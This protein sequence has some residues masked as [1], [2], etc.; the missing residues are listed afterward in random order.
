MQTLILSFQDFAKRAA[1]R[2]KAKSNLLKTL[3]KNTRGRGHS[4]N[5]TNIPLQDLSDPFPALPETFTSSPL[6]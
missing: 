5:G 2:S 1:Q 3:R 4:G 6:A